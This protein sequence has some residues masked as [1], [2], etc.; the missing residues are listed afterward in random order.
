MTDRFRPCVRAVR[1]RLC[2]GTASGGSPFPLKE[3]GGAAL[4][5]ALWAAGA[6]L[7]EDAG[8]L[9]DSSLA[10]LPSPGSSPCS[11]WGVMVTTAA[12]GKFFVCSLSLLA[13]WSSGPAHGQG[14]L[15]RHRPELALGWSAHPS[16]PALRV[17]GQVGRGCWGT[18]HKVSSGGPDSGGRVCS[19][20]ENVATL[21]FQDGGA[22]VQ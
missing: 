15:P 8:I 11:S 14:C 20:P 10:P 7:G 2:Q 17:D 5:A 13:S 22:M 19:D 12:T 16:S 6:H 1:G 9:V 21:Y 3:L 18:T 4:D